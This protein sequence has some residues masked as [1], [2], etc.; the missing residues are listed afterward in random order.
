MSNPFF[1]TGQFAGDIVALEAELRTGLECFWQ[2]AATIL[3]GSTVKLVPPDAKNYSLSRNFFST[4][5][6]YSY[7]RAGIPSERRILYVAVN[8]CLRGMVTGCDNILDDE[9]KTTLETDLPPQAH[10]FRSVLDIMVADRVLF[11]ILLDYCQKNDLPVERVLRA[12]AVSL[13]ALMQSGAQE[14]SEEGGV[15]EYL[16]PDALLR[17]IHHYKTGLLFQSTWAIPALFEEVM[18]PAAQTVREALYQIGIG[19]Q[20]L[21]DLADLFIDMRAQR[22]NYVVSVVV[23]EESAAVWQSLQTWV[24]AAET[25]GPF[26]AAWPELATRMK[27]KAL[28]TLENGLRHLF[29]DKHQDVVRP[30]A[31]FIADRIGVSLDQQ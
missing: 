19:C 2:T 21:D 11:A 5:F 6:L 16:L 14:A 3:D 18:T 20:M 17:E 30:A 22:H 13:Q 27:K 31:V 10:R 1:V 28:A 23:H 24:A 8:Q 12:S 26:F 29:L 9:Y 15:G 4:L 7:Y 25:P